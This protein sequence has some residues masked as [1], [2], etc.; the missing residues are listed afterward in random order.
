MTQ[1]HNRNEGISRSPRLNASIAAAEKL[2]YQKNDCVIVL[3]DLFPAK[4]NKIKRDH[5]ETLSEIT[6]II[7]DGIGRGRMK[8]NQILLKQT[9]CGVIFTGEYYIG[10]GSDVARLLPLSFKNPIEHE[11]LHECQK[12]PLILSTFYHFFIR[13]YAE[14]Y[15][16][17]KAF[18][19]NWLTV[20][21]NMKFNVHP[22]LKETYFCLL[23]AYKL[24]LMYFAK[25]DY[26]TRDI[27][28][29]ESNRFQRMLS[30]LIHAQDKNVR[31]STNDKTEKN[32]Y[33]ELVKAFYNANNFKYAKSADRLDDCDGIVHEK[34]LCLRGEKLLIKIK[35]V[36]PNATIHDIR[37]SL[38]EHKSLYLD[39]EGKNKKIGNK[40][41]YA[42]PI[43][44][45]K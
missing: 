7:A 26:I 8:G 27:A 44:M 45:L 30:D 6:R 39:G 41:L 28:R 29:S 5:E 21:R 4:S 16:E 32:N 1:I 40:R 3:D 23:S 14:N 35:R 12:E 18:L 20:N 2:L 22:R 24:L 37:N 36:F 9:T 19:G 11:K 13:W 17:I 42:I 43:K 10:T 38:I 25:I 15:S 31:K 33:F 34:Y